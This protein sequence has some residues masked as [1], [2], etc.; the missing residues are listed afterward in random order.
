MPGCKKQRSGET[1]KFYVLDTGYLD[2]EKDSVVH[3]TGGQPD[4]SLLIMPVLAFLIVHPSGLILYDT[5]SN[6]NAMKGYWPKTMQKKFALHQL[7]SQRLE[8]QLS[9]IGV[10][11]EEIGTIIL[12]HLH[13]DHTGGLPLFPHAQ[14]Y[15][16]RADY[17]NALLSIH[18]SSDP[19]QHGGYIFGDLTAPLK[20]VHLIEEEDFEF[21]PGIQIV[22]LPGHTP[23]LLGLVLHCKNGVYLLPQDAA[24][25][26]ANYENPPILPR[27]PFDRDLYR[28]SISKLHQLQEQ[29]GAQIIFPHDIQQFQ[30]L[31]KAPEFYD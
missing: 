29:Y 12:S 31:R 20:K 14:V 18:I 22:N 30:T 13:L 19:E 10:R 17:I 8:R 2:G 16:P 24:Y 7:P 4:K 5:G 9:R 1:M 25:V 6:P 15:V 11:P 21:L 28:A 23:G 3:D 26:S 27:S